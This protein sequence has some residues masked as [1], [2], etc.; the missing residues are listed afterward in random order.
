MSSR[1]DFTE[2]DA[3]KNAAQS[4]NVNFSDIESSSGYENKLW[5]NSPLSGNRNDGYPTHEFKGLSL[6]SANDLPLSADIVPLK[7]SNG[8]QDEV[9]SDEFDVMVNDLRSIFLCWLKKT[10]N[11]LKS[12]RENLIREAD[13]LQKEK[14]AFVQKIKQERAIEAEKL[15][16]DRRRQN[17]EIASQLKQ[18]QIERED[19]RRRIEDDW[20]KLEHEKDV[21]RKYMQ[22][23]A[24]KLK[25][26]I[27][28]LEQEKR[29]VVDSKIA[30][31]TMVDINV[32]GVVFE[33][34]RHTLTRQENSYLNGLLSGRYEIG[35]DRQGR[36]FLDRD[37]ELFRIILNFLRNPTSLPI[38]SRD[39]TESAMI[40]DEAKY[41]KIKFSPY[42]L[43]LCYGGHNGKEHLK[44]MELLDMESKVWRNCNPMTTE[45]MYFGSG[46]LSNFL[47]VFGGQNLDYK[48]LCDVEM[49][50]R[51]RDTWQAA[52]PLKHPRRNNAGMTLE[53]R[54]FCVG[55]FDGMNIL[56]SVETYDMRMK[57]WIPVAPLKVPR[58][59]AMVT[60]QNGS[61]YAIGGTN[62]ERLKSV[63][64]YDVRKN[65]W[66]LINNGLL[67]VRSA[68][69]VCTY[70]NEM[71]IAGGID[72]LQSIHS[73]VETWDS[74]NQTSSFL[75]DV[76][77]P[78]MDGAM[79]ATPHSVVLVGGQN[80]KILDSTFFYQ[81]E[82][83]QWTQGPNL[84]MPR[85]GHCTTVLDF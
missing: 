48:A 78:V 42:P 24:E 20:C 43:V 83:D 7:I 65:E 39:L 17:A 46:V 80:T 64:R 72:N 36:I 76:P 70:L 61:L 23:E 40:L 2:K 75:K 12:Q 31:E 29:K 68:G 14:N 3:G 67:E 37:Y 11:S 79:A 8:A 50:D 33:T 56:D 32:G 26:R 63:E 41:Y 15:A 58:S 13:E 27:E 81:P 71:F 19:S 21:F 52:A 10:Q 53:E 38:P 4:T 59:S 6:P 73:S 69:S 74:K 45:R 57:N 25:Q 18:I 51:L 47:Y 84:I 55:G 9:G 5:L 1:L 22:L 49:Y 44:S 62:G 85:Y 54:I 66:E 16:E 30:S 35:R 77:V 82:S 60:H 34:S 28:L